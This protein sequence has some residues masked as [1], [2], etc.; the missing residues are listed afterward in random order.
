VTYA[1]FIRYKKWYGTES[2]HR[3][4]GLLKLTFSVLL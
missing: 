4:V 1:F 3:T 2:A